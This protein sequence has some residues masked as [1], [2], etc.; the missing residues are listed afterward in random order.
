VSNV[1]FPLLLLAAMF[2]SLVIEHFLP[3]IP[4]INARILLMPLVVFYGAVALP[5][6]GMLVLAFIGGLM[7][8]L[9]HVQY[10]GQGGEPEIAVGFSI[11]LYVILGGIMSGFRPWFQRGR[12]EVHCLLCG[13]LTAALPLAEYLML[14]IR[15]LPVAIT[16]NEQIWWR[17]GGSGIAAV[18]L[19]PFYFFALNYFAL[20]LGYELTP[21]P[22]EKRP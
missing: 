9:L 19:A 11:I 3:S 22:E 1:F 5:T 8:D 2:G 10:I 18:F 13:F 4:G 7:W 21:Q 14:S 15:R 20:L 16:F 17:I 12:W 6:W